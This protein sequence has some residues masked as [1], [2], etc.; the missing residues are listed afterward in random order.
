MVSQFFDH[1][2][3]S[4]VLILNSCSSE[5]SVLCELF[6]ACSDCAAVLLIFNGKWLRFLSEPLELAAR[7]L[8]RAARRKRSASGSRP[9]VDAVGGGRGSAFFF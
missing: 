1:A 5:P 6:C 7:F 4:L 3:G 2:G 9:L 8:R